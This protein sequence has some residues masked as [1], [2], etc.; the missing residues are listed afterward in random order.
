MNEEVPKSTPAM[1]SSLYPREWCWR[2]GATNWIEEV[3]G[4][5]LSLMRVM[6]LARMV[7]MFDILR[8][9]VISP[10]TAIMLWPASLTQTCLGFLWGWCRQ[11]DAQHGKNEVRNVETQMYHRCTCMQHTVAAAIIER[12]VQ[13]RG[14]SGEAQANNESLSWRWFRQCSRWL[15]GVQGRGHI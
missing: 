2:G 9:E 15:R 1:D 13:R 4:Q 5:F 14:F 6:L 12:F 8:L 7:W 3:S 11:T 10:L